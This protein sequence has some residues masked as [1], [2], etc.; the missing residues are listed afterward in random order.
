MT[1][2]DTT[3]QTTESGKGMAKE[4]GFATSGKSKF[5]PAFWTDKVYRPS[6]GASDGQRNV[7]Q[8]YARMQHEGRREAVALGT[9]D[10]ATAARKAAK[11]FQRVKA[12]GWDVALAEHSPDRAKA[13]GIPT[14]GEFIAAAEQ[15]VDVSPSSLQKYV[16]CFRRIVAAAFG[17]RSDESKYDYRKG[18]LDAFRARVDRIKLDK[19]TPARVQSAL[20]KRIQKARGNPLAEQSARTS[21]AA[22][23][24]QAKSLFSKEIKLP[25]ASLPNPF[26]GV[27]VKVGTPR[28]YQSTIDAAAL[29]R[30]GLRELAKRDPEAFKALLLALGAG[31]RKAE[32]DNLQWNHIDVDTGTIRV[33]TTATFH[34][35]TDSSE[36]D[37]FV[38]PGLI[39][40]LQTYR[41]KATS[42][43]VL[44]SKLQPKPGARHA[45]YRAAVTFDR[46]TK[47]LR[48]NG[49]T[50]NK[51]MHDLRKEFGSIV[52]GIA[53]IHTASRQLRH[54]SIQTTAAFYA[55]SRR[56]VAPSIG[57]MLA[58]QTIA[59]AGK[60]GAKAKAGKKARSK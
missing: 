50:A 39:A 42:L 52:C 45:Y 7:Q 10:K 3:S 8:W 35:K 20:T 9:N 53:D 11:L 6:Y 60:K 32:I 12:A 43:F 38:D 13:K 57:A 23:L 31:L 26:D 37:V 33:Q 16:S 30:A 5:T 46:L 22:L 27:K 14:V 44:E 40:A 54:A 19:V 29:M 49:V 25:F 21:A 41:D 47:W 36:G 24:R 15:V 18:G 48:S 51:P 28:K 55:D 17:I 59:K 56:R 1:N 4:S 58:P 2:H 34:A